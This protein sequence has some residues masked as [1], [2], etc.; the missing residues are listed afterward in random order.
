MPQGQ[1]DPK[2]RLLMQI[3]SLDDDDDE[4]TGISKKISWILRHGAKAANVKQ[5]PDTKW[6]KFSDMCEC[7]LLCEFGQD[8][9][10]QVVVDF[11]G[12]KL[13]YEIDDSAGGPWIR[14][15]KRDDKYKEAAKLGASTAEVG[16]AQAS[17]KGARGAGLRLEAADFKPGQP[18][19]AAAGA[20]DA[21]TRAMQMHA[22]YAAQLQQQ[23]QQ[24]MSPYM[25]MMNPMMSPY[26]N[27]AYLYQQQ[28]Q[29]AAAAAAHQAQAAA[30]TTAASSKLQGRIKSFNKEKGFG[31]IECLQTF[32]Q[33]NRDVF[34]HKAQIGDMQVGAFVSFTC[35]ANKQGM[36]QAKDVQS[37]GAVPPHVQQQLLGA[38]KGGAKGKGGGKDGKGKA[39]D[40]KGKGRGRGEGGKGKGG[41]EGRG[42]GAG[43]KAN[44]QPAEGAAAAS[45]EKAEVPAAA[46]APAPAAEASKEPAAETAAA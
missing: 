1:K 3:K 45:E 43:K 9:I 24:Q 31:F 37:L 36:P 26:M 41:G 11:N 5:N 39:G 32:Q 35:E 7:E 18:V 20:G 15:H 10:W 14:A 28:Q 4:R 25:G 42:K 21:S 38:S 27:Q 46:E 33:Y 13:R 29:Q 40:G 17:D 22:A 16:V 12:K 8:M 44:E 6:V 2:N 34:L 30:A 23:Q 19:A